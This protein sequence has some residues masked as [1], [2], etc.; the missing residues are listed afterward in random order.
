MARRLDSGRLVIASHNP[1]K[2]VEITAL[3]EPYRVE[4]LDAT[5]LGLAEPEE[6]GATFE[7]NA[8]LKAHAAAQA[9]GLAALADDSGLVV[10]A[11]GGAP[12]VYSARWA[13]PGKDFSVAMARVDR[14]LGNRDRAA[15][16]VSVLALAWTGGEE[17]LFRGEVHGRLSWPPRGGNGFGYDPIFIPEGYSQTF[18][19]MAAEE[20]YRIDHRARAFAK[21]VAACFGANE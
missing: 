8:A 9:A 3:L 2:V 13:G 6:T 19:E 1:G 16:F 18:G 21:L 4:I 15:S 14:E 5:E 11:L 17:A 12:G 7:E 20:K 10:P